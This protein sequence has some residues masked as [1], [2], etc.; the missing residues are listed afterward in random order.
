MN[1][2]ENCRLALPYWQP[3]EVVLNREGW[4]YEQE[5]MGFASGEWLVGEGDL[6]YAAYSEGALP[7][8]H[9]LNEGEGPLLFFTHYNPESDVTSEWQFTPEQ[10]ATAVMCLEAPDLMAALEALPASYRRQ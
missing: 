7:T 3:V 6:C 10:V 8:E 9:T 1:T 5:D 4:H 2:H